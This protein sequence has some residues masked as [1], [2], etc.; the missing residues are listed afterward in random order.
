MATV[1]QPRPVEG[2][3]RPMT[4]AD[5]PQVMDVE[6]DAYPFPWSEQIFRDCLRVGYHCLVVDTPQGVGGYGVMSTGAGEA[7]VLNVCVGRAL[8]GRGM[9]RALMHAMLD[10]AR[11]VGV[12]LVFLEVR[13]SNR[14]A[15][16]LYESMGFERIG[17]R[18]GYYQASWG[19]EDAFVYRLALVPQPPA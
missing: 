5:V 2:G 19:R 15:I 14:V 1:R 13:P 8:R 12:E 18:P 3:F 11:A 17:L 7:H 4:D 6:F 9:G 10:H 16:A